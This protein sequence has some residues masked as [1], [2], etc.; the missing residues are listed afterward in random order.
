MVLLT[1]IEGVRFEL[2]IDI[3]RVN[4]VC[5]IVDIAVVI[6]I[7]ISGIGN[8]VIDDI[9][10]SGRIAVAFVCDGAVVVIKG[11]TNLVLLVHL[12][13]DDEFVFKLLHRPHLMSNESNKIY[14]TIT[15]E[16][17]YYK[18]SIEIA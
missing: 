9:V 4:V 3:T 17:F 7:L 16:I 14:T 2:I 11:V 15:T 12:T 13:H 6:D 5:C 18:C 10:L 8:V 1:V